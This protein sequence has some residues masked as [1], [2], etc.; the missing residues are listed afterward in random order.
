LKIHKVSCSLLRIP[1]TF[2]LVREQQYALANFIEIETDQSHRGHA[3][4]TYPLKHGIREFIN[5]EAAPVS[6]RRTHRVSLAGMEVR[7]STVRRRARPV[8]GYMKL[9]TSPDLG[10]TPKPGILDLAIE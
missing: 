7:G 3:L 1:F 4:S 2:P 8:N 9:P 10:F 5:Q 6:E